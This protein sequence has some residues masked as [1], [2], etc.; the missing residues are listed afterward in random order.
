MRRGLDRELEHLKYSMTDLGAECERLLSL[1]IQLLLQ[2]GSTPEM[3]W[4]EEA[5]SLVRDVEAQCLTLLLRR[6]PVARDL[7][8]VSAAL[9]IASDLQRIADQALDVA[10]IASR[11]GPFELPEA[12][13]TMAQETKGMVRDA[14]DAFVHLDGERAFGVID[15]DDAV[16]AAYQKVKSSLA[17]QD[18]LAVEAALN[19]LLIAKYFERIADHGV[20]IARHV[21]S[22]VGEEGT[23]S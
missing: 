14:I 7:R 9:K 6:Q 2:R 12:L 4:K 21:L 8:E 15:A 1:A 22:V 13:M 3:N 16:D 20:N 11:E 17:G 5:S 10:N 23:S 19:L 18:D